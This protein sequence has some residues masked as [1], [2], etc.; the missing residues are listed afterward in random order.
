MQR[1]FL[2]R[3]IDVAVLGLVGYV[4]VVAATNRPAKPQVSEFVKNV[5]LAPLKQAAIQAVGRIS[6]F[7]SHARQ[8]VREI[9]GPAGVAGSG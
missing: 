7:D 5:D 3:T 9:A 1:K 2:V 8:I 4:V 6:S